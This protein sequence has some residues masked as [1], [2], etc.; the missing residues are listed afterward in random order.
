MLT[1]DLQAVLM[2]LQMIREAFDGPMEFFRD[3]C[4]VDSDLLLSLK[5]LLTV[6]RDRDSGSRLRCISARVKRSLMS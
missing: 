5:A 1:P 4:H 2:L 6:P 3:G